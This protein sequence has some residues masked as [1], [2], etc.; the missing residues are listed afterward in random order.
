[1]PVTELH[2]KI[3]D[4]FINETI[5]AIEKMSGISAQPG[6]AFTDRVDGFRFK[7]YAVA[8]ETTGKINGVI[9][10][11]HYIETALGIGNKVIQMVIGTP[12]EQTEITDDIAEALS[13]W[14]NTA[15]GRATRGLAES[16]LGI[17]FKPPHFV[18]NSEEMMALLNGVIDI[19]S[20]PIHVSNVG[21]FYFNYLI[22]GYADNQ[23]LLVEPHEKI[24]IVDDMKMIR[25]SMKSY[26]KTLGYEN[27]VEAADGEEAVKLH[28]QEKPAFIFMDVVMPKMTGNAALAKIRSTGARTP[29]VMLSSMAD[30]ELISECE[31]HGI[32]GYVIKPLTTVTGPETLK[33]YLTG[34]N[35]ST[36]ANSAPDIEPIAEMSE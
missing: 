16:N 18:H 8:A 17:R 35:T 33:Q 29:I 13:E 31:A 32:S 30:Q 3:L 6:D 1:M 4:P 24:M 36:A 34:T 25:T 12:S 7:G 14:C 20:V 22:K 19:I 23:R 21:R 15:I 27:V 5:T 9:L 28:A 10:M 11:H 26:L 2:V